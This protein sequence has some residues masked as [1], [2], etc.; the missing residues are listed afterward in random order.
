MSC[1]FLSLSLFVFYFALGF[2]C[3][4]CWSL[5]F[6]GSLMS[7][8]LC[9]ACAHWLTQKTFSTLYPIPTNELNTGGSEYFISTAGFF[10]LLRRHLLFI[11]FSKGDCT[12]FSQF[13]T[14]FIVVPCQIAKILP[15]VNDG[16]FLRQWDI[17]GKERERKRKKM[18][19]RNYFIRNEMPEI[20]KIWIG[21]SIRILKS[22]KIASKLHT[23]LLLFPCF[24]LFLLYFWT[25][26]NSNRHKIV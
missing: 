25:K 1:L 15:L 19:R 16:Q 6:Y 23:L 21:N 4:C 24:F 7:S 11:Q 10:F 8:S 9:F 14:I 13:N 3:F 22:R 2:F 18:F 20:V 17:S 26:D 12:P 5:A